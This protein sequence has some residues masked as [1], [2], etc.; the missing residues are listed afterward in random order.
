MAHRCFTLSTSTLVSNNV[1]D[2]HTGFDVEYTDLTVYVA[3]NK[4]DGGNRLGA[5]AYAVMSS[6][7][8]ILN[9][10]DFTCRTI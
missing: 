7:D 3:G 1:L 9:V 2:L 6:S 5:G 8:K 10:C 4:A